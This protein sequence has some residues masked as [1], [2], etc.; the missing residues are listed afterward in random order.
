[1]RHDEGHTARS[2]RS[3]VTIHYAYDPYVGQRAG[4]PDTTRYHAKLS[5]RVALPHGATTHLPVWM[6]RPEAA[7]L[8]RAHRARHCAGGVT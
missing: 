7:N 2:H 5:Y 4:V 1:M 8:P 6:A 3:E